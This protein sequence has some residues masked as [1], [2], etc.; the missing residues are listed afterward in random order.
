MTSLHSSVSHSQEEEK[1][2]THCKH[3]LSV[4][5]KHPPEVGQRNGSHL[6]AHHEQCQ[7]LFRVTGRRSPGEEM[8]L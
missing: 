3:L 2:I 7:L 5:A 4:V 6:V 8:K 1:K